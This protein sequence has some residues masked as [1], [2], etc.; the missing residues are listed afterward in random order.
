[1]CGETGLPLTGPAAAARRYDECIA[2][3]DSAVEKGR[4]LRADY[5]L[6]GRA[7]TRKVGRGVAQQRCGRLCSH[8]LLPRCLQHPQQLAPMLQLCV[9]PA[10]THLLSAASS[11][12]T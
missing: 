8:A 1:M 4:E 3:C 9:A 2:D 10:R 11:T 6:I 12:T 7:M 5:K